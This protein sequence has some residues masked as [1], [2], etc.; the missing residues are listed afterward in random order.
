MSDA[1]ADGGDASSRS[2]ISTPLQVMDDDSSVEVVMPLPTPEEIV[3]EN[4]H[5]YVGLVNQAMTCYLNSLIQTLYMTPEFRNAI[6]QYKV[7]VRASDEKKNIPYQLQKLFLLLQTSDSVSLETKDLTASFGWHGTEAYDQH[8]VQEFYSL[9]VEA[10]EHHFR[11]SESHRL[12]LGELYRG[13]YDDYV[14]CLKCGYEGV[15]SVPF[16]DLILAVHL[17]RSDSE[18]TVPVK[19]V[20]EALRE[21]VS[22]ESLT[23]QNQYFCGRC[24]SHQ[25]GE[26][27]LRIT[28]FPYLLTI[29][30]KRFNYGFSS[31]KLNERISFS[32]LFNLNEFV[33]DSE[34]RGVYPAPKL[35]YACA[36]KGVKVEVDE[37]AGHALDLNAAQ[38]MLQQGPNVY[39]LY[40]VM[41]HQGSASGGHY[42]AYIKNMDQQKWFCFNDTSVT[43]AS[44]DDIKRVFGGPAGGWSVS[45][46]NAYLLMYRR[47]DASRNTK[48]I[49][50]PNLPAHLAELQSKW[51]KEEQDRLK[52]KEYEDSLVTVNV[53]FNGCGCGDLPPMIENIPNETKL[54]DVFLLAYDHFDE[55]YSALFSIRKEDCRL[56]LCGNQFI[57]HSTFDENQMIEITLKGLE[58]ECEEF[59]FLPAYSARTDFYFMMD[60]KPPTMQT[61]YP[62]KH[63]EGRTVLVEEIDL[64]T[65]IFYG[66]KVWFGITETVGSIKRKLTKLARNFCVQDAKNMRIVLDKSANTGNDDMTLLDCEDMVFSTILYTCYGEVVLYT[67]TGCDPMRA[68]ND[69]KVPFV[70]SVFFRHLEKKKFG[71]M[72]RIKIPSAADFDKAGF[73]APVWISSGTLVNFTVSNSL[74]TV[75]SSESFSKASE[76]II[77]KNS[78]EI[79]EAP[80][81]YEPSP[82]FSNQQSPDC[83]P[84][85]SDSED[86]GEQM[87]S[88]SVDI[89]PIFVSSVPA[90][91][92]S[93][94]SECALHIDMEV[95][96]SDTN[97]AQEPS[98]LDPS[99]GPPDYFRCASPRIIDEL[100]MA[101][102]SNALA[103]HPIAILSANRGKREI[104]IATD[105]RHLMKNVAEWLAQYLSLS[106]SQFTILKHYVKHDEGYETSFSPQ[107]TLKEAC[108]TV[109]SLSV[110]FR[111][112]LKDNEKMIRVVA[113]ELNDSTQQS[114]KPLFEIPASADLRIEDFLKKCQSALENQLGEAVPL[115]LLRLRD[116]THL[117]VPSLSLQSTFRSRGVMWSKNVYLQ[118]LD[119]ETDNLAAGNVVMVRRWRPHKLEVSATQEVV[120][121]GRQN[122]VY[123]ELRCHL[124]NISKIPF[125]RIEISETFPNCAWMKWPYEKGVI[126][127]C[128]SVRFSQNPHVARSVVNGKLIY[129]KDS[130][131]KRKPLTEEERKAI[132]IKEDA[133]NATVSANSQHASR[134]RERPLRIQMSSSISE[135]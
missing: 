112:P 20:Q 73:E 87:I 22:P 101:T 23:E 40:S 66:K 135:T 130:A 106:L 117:G 50:T 107:A 70:D 93:L 16:N 111:S 86:C 38:E 75:A 85:V 41:V 19:T 25:D 18:A 67:D 91:Q 116:I 113:F 99:G 124:A 68:R 125:E 76:M 26:K 55:N 1:E 80:R 109:D 98:T 7:Q 97:I 127:L 95:S 24:N 14:K 32:D 119:E 58:N 21:F 35:S 51:M 120:L 48:F 30:L 102:T 36:T 131:E 60:I 81:F 105:Q 94:M 59:A 133:A 128:E 61:F 37:E 45:N 129:F 8:D 53:M 6:Y 9:M 115:K 110:K 72:L 57:I 103:R 10:L 71:M 84:C 2:T 82:S 104:V 31:H 83:S 42:F 46:T 108:L 5:R 132:K 12:I 4:G 123:T 88:V 122:D 17:R 121:T 28:E 43:N 134:R 118:V 74:T 29:Q 49:R 126:A 56:L 65:G 27:G 62:V 3:D 39:E 100:A 44:P 79:H 54:E 63:D 92:G 34:K 64:D 90:G 96:D 89:A 15:K 52:A 77:S 47:V 13:S 11:K 33:F 78:N 69:R 114:W